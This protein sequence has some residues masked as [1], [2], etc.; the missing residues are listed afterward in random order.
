TQTIDPAAIAA[1]SDDGD[2]IEPAALVRR[3]AVGG[4]DA[5]PAAAWMRRLQVARDLLRA[6]ATAAARE[7]YERI[8]GE[9]PVCR[10]Y[11]YAL[12]DLAAIELNRGHADSARQLLAEA[13]RSADALAL[14]DL[15]A[16]R[17]ATLNSAIDA[18]QP[19]VPALAP[20]P[21]AP[22]PTAL[23]SAAPASV[24]R[25]VPY[26]PVLVPPPV[27]AP[28]PAATLRVAVEY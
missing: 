4:A 1:G 5:S 16:D 7:T 14:D 22:A 17:I 6:G 25:A 27:L 15:S 8:V 13:H 23:A 24:A 18:T 12:I 21:A 3:D 19:A 9:A 26:G 11:Q 2:G 20:S 10:A 28:D